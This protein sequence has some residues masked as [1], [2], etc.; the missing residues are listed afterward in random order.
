MVCAA[1]EG[2]LEPSKAK[3]ACV[4]HLC[5]CM[6]GQFA[7]SPPE[8]SPPP[9]K[10]EDEAPLPT[11]RMGEFTRCLRRCFTG[12]RTRGAPWA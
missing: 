3:Q 5:E 12:G 8:R 10:P 1:S 9:W 11:E 7:S 4:A 6:R 2:H